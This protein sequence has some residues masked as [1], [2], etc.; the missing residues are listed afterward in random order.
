MESLMDYEEFITIVGEAGGASREEAEHATRA[1]LQTLAERIDRAQARDV[2]AELPPQVAP[3]MATVTPLEGF[4]IDEFIRRIAEREGVDAATAERHARAVLMAVA[5]AI[6]AK[7]LSEV[8]SELPDDFAPLMPR[9]RWVEVL[10]ADDFYLRVAER[11]GIDVDPARRLT[12]AVLETLGERVPAGEV[13]DLVARLPRDLHAPLER[14]AEREPNATS[15]PL[16]AFLRRVAERAGV[17]GPLDVVR[18]NEIGEQARAVLGVLR[19]A[20]GDEEFFDVT[21]ELSDDYKRVLV[22]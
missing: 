21:V 8:L 15:M 20:V 17:S 19:E 7:E 18:I 12:D 5:R 9:G 1:T 11:A 13:R 4:H 2:A 10:P 22:R 3:F 14:G 16:D 6:S